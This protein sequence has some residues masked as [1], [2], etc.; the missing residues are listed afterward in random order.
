MTSQTSEV[1]RRLL[2]FI[3][4]TMRS[5]ASHSIEDIVSNGLSASRQTR[6]D[7]KWR[8][9]VEA[10]RVP[11]R[12]Y[13]DYADEKGCETR[14][15]EWE[16]VVPRG[17]RANHSVANAGNPSQ[18]QDQSVNPIQSTE[19]LAPCTNDLSLLLV[20]TRVYVYV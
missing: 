12:L 9:P 1:A 19:G 7:E 13:L 18:G 16:K 8:N 2:V 20:R 14:A 4:A 6:S 11:L 10:S 3:L 5:F 15:D 17:G